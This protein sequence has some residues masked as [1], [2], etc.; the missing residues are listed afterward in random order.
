MYNFLEFS[1]KQLFEIRDA[2]IMLAKF[3]L[4]NQNLLTEINQELNNRREK[5]GEQKHP[6]SLLAYPGSYR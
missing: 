2:S 6:D 4:H 5:E 3:N 1:L